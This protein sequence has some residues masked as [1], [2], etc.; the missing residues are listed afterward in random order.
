MESPFKTVEK[1]EEN[2]VSQKDLLIYYSEHYPSKLII[3]W[4][5][6]NNIKLIK[7]REFCF[8]LPNDE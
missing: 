7:N 3:N 8:T 6:R 1:K 2:L 4:L 5:C